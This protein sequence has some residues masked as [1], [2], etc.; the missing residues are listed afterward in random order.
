MKFRKPPEIALP[1]SARWY[2]VIVF[3]PAM[4][5]WLAAL[6]I[7][8]R[9]NAFHAGLCERQGRGAKPVHA[10]PKQ[11]AQHGRT[12]DI[13][14]DRFFLARGSELRLI[15]Q[16]C[17]TFEYSRRIETRQAILGGPELTL[18]ETPSEL[19]MLPNGEYSEV[20]PE[21]HPDRSRP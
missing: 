4:E 13:W 20:F 19:L 6:R 21:M 18:L 8:E 7:P 14:P 16:W 17:E 3:E 12:F 15:L 5:L 10:I 1:D 9:P 2:G 11:L